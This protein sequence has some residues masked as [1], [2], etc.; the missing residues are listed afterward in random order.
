MRPENPYPED[1][2]PD[3]RCYGPAKIWEAACRAYEEALGE[4]RGEVMSIEKAKTVLD[5]ALQ[6]CQEYSYKDWSRQRVEELI[7]EVKVA[8]NDEEAQE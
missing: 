4:A 7:R 3:G 8:L 5:K 1:I 6:R 2:T